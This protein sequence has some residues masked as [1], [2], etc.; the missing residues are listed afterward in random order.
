MKPLPFIN[1]EGY[2]VD[3]NHDK[4]ELIAAAKEVLVQSSKF[5]F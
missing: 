4:N 1:L 3:R 2:V 5:W